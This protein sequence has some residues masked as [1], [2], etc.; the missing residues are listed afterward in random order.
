MNIRRFTLDDYE[1][2]VD[3]Y[4]AFAKEV[5]SNR[6]LGYKYSFYK[7]VDEWIQR[8]YDIILATKDSAICGFSMC[9]VDDM[10]GIT[11][12]VYNANLAYVKPTY[13]NSRASYMLY[14]NSY[15]Y[16]KDMNLKIVTIGRSENKVDEMMEKHFDLRK[17][18]TMY[19]GA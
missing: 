13:R 5:Y 10:D 2:V 6:K 14:K 7:I 4:Y 15:Q 3:M 9:Y 19:E 18:Y 17:T 8:R 1:E 11:E 12:P 16:A